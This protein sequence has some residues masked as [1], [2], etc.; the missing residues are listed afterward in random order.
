MGSLVGR[1]TGLRPTETKII[2]GPVNDWTTVTRLSSLQF[3]QY[4]DWEIVTPT[5]LIRIKVKSAIQ[6]LHCALETRHMAGETRKAST[7]YSFCAE[8]LRR[9][10]FALFLC[11]WSAVERRV[12]PVLMRTRQSEPCSYWWGLHVVILMMSALVICK[13]VPLC[14]TNT[15]YENVQL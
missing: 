9:R 10:K 4:S 13:L 6:H 7:F 2:S 15:G 3:S 5:K 11:S 8:N 12:D 1:R 14:L